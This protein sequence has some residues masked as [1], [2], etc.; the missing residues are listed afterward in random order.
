MSQQL[1]FFVF[2]PDNELFFMELYLQLKKGVI[3][4]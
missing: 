3:H 4:F 1:Y 2:T